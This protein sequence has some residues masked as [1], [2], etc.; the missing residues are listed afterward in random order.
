[1]KKMIAELNKILEEASISKMLRTAIEETIKALKEKNYE[2]AFQLTGCKSYIIGEINSEIETYAFREDSKRNERVLK[3]SVYSI[4]DGIHYD[5]AIKI[6]KMPSG[7]NVFTSKGINSFT[8]QGDHPIIKRM[9][10][11][12]RAINERMEKIYNKRIK[13][14]KNLKLL[15]K[16]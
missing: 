11:E 16:L 1:M 9:R 12:K 7:M 13:K 3:N 15:Q 8:I 10:F 5:L 6:D 2:L 4:L 14:W